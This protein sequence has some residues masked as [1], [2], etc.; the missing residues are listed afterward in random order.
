M[1]TL[2]K[3]GRRSKL[4][5]MPRTFSRT[6]QFR[7]G[8]RVAVSAVSTEDRLRPLHQHRGVDVLLGAEVAVQRAQ[9]D[10]GRVGDVAHLDLVVVLGLEQRPAPR[11]RSAT[12]GPV[13]SRASRS[14]PGRPFL[15]R[16]R[17]IVAMMFSWISTVPP[18]MTSAGIIR[19]LRHRGLLAA[20]DHRRAP[21][22]GQRVG[23]D[24][25]HHQRGRD[26]ADAGGRPGPVPGEPAQGV[27]HRQRADGIGGRPGSRRARPD[28]ASS[29]GARRRPGTAVHS[30]C[31]A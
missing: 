3:A 17:I 22:E 27:A 12:G 21:A 14:W 19:L 30:P 29:V 20:A 5:M 7:P 1:H 18:P 2:K 10:V 15:G 11:P 4:A 9:C 28:R 13:C 31:P 25:A 26:L 16:P 23:G 6:R 24:P 8:R